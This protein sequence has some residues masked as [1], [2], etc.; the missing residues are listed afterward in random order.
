MLFS[1]A[2]TGCVV[3]LAPALP[4]VARLHVLAL[5]A[6]VWVVV[7][8]TVV[9]IALRRTLAWP[10]DRFS[11][12]ATVTAMLGIGLAVFASAEQAIVRWWFDDPS[13]IWH[14]DWR[15]ALNHAYTV[16][17]H[18]GIQRALD[19]AGVPVDYHIGPAW[20]AG[21]AGRILGIDVAFLLLGILPFVS[22]LALTMS[23]ILFLNGFGVPYRLGSAAV[24][25]AYAVPGV[26]TIMPPNIGWVMDNPTSTLLD[27]ENLFFVGVMLNSLFGLAVGVAGFVLLTRRGVSLPGRVSGVLGLAS[28]IV[29]KPQYF[30]GLGALLGAVAMLRG[31][32]S[33]PPGSWNWQT[34]MWSTATLACALLMFWLSPGF[35]A[36]FSGVEWAPGGTVYA[37]R[38][39]WAELSTVPVVVALAVLL[40]GLVVGVSTGQGTLRYELRDPMA[41][42][43][44]SLLALASL[45]VVFYVCR[46]PVKV[47]LVERA[48]EM[49]NAG[50]ALAQETN[51]LQSMMPVRLL[52]LVVGLACAF[53][54]MRAVYRVRHGLGSLLALVA[55]LLALLPL[56]AMIGSAANPY[57]GHE[58][59][60]DAS[61]FTVL[62]QVPTADSVLIASDLADPANN[63][64]RTL[65]A[66]LLNAYH[67]HTF[68]MSNLRYVHWVRES[69]PRRRQELEIFFGSNWSPWHES[70][71]ITTGITHVLVNQRCRPAWSDQQVLPL[72]QL[73][74]AAGGDWWTVYLVE[75]RNVQTEPPVTEPPWEV[76]TPNYGVSGCLRF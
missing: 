17:N 5:S 11:Q 42:L 65:N 19:F 49:G 46:F 22:G 57:R 25:L 68:Y 26:L 47:G 55:G 27:V 69:A 9:L 15:Y 50:W 10:R 1:T 6:V 30:V 76:L 13:L 31:S 3:G 36:V 60:A 52:A 51:L 74:S 64:L 67:G 45:A 20:L 38:L 71:L 24:A 7:T 35:P 4:S 75:K 59:V 62:A 34:L 32:D 8:L 2:L 40:V 28:V 16:L 56:P 44:G 72:R 48:A 66:P 33:T 41:L 58:A 43:S 39:G 23:L 53:L 37:D 54:L 70:W 63:H 18:G 61:L 73:A 21:A 12:V 29:I 14:I